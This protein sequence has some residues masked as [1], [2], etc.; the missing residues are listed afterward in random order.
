MPG[1]LPWT[2][3]G[4][5]DPDGFFYE[6]RRVEP[7]LPISNPFHETW[8]L[9]S[10]RCAKADNV[11]YSVFHDDNSLPVIFSSFSISGS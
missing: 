8:S 10:G 3:G 9:D 6:P 2:A 7:D 11:G 5:D 4:L 1:C